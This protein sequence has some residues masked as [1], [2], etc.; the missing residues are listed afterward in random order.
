MVVPFTT[1]LAPITDSPALSSTVPVTLLCAMAPMANMENK[2]TKNARFEKR[3]NR[4]VILSFIRKVIKLVNR[5]VI[6]F[7]TV[8]LHLISWDFA[9]V[10]LSK[11]VQFFACFDN[12][13][14]VSAIFFS[15]L[16]NLSGFLPLRS[17]FTASH[18]PRPASNISDFCR[19]APSNRAERSKARRHA[20]G[21]RL[22]PSPDG[23][24]SPP[25]AG[26]RRSS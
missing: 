5:L 18:K 13:F 9:N 22:R 10:K 26:T 11:K 3:T 24:S 20:P 4:L 23:G 21:R 15:V 25:R 17:T 19:H 2:A 6:E 1:T 14:C 12:Y 16:I 8:L 7:C